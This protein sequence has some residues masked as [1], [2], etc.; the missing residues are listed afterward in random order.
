MSVRKN[1][2]QEMGVHVG[3]PVYKGQTVQVKSSRTLIITCLRRLFISMRVP[4]RRII[5][6]VRAC[7][8]LGAWE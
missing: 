8:T 4:G 6:V 3:A 7:V 2:A 1:N 5:A